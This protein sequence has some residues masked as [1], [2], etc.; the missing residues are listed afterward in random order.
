MSTTTP[1]YLLLTEGGGPDCESHWR[2][3]LQGIDSAQALSAT[4][5]EPLADAERVELLAVVRGLEALEEPARVTLIT[6][7]RYVQQGLARGLQE[8]RDNCWQWERFGRIVPVRDFDLWQ[9]VDQALRFHQV[10]CRCWRFDEAET[11][12]AGVSRAP[13]AGPHFVRRRLRRSIGAK[14]QTNQSN[15]W[16]ERP[17]LQRADRRRWVPSTLP[18]LYSTAAR[19]AASPLA[20]ASA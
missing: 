10:E 7:S 2:F 6:R 8:W 9:R 11:T 12:E 15:N 19:V 5:K 4:D 13:L 18:N 17:L 3:V 16:D 20:Q 14:S 1:H